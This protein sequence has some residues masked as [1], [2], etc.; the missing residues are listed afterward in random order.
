MS[1]WNESE[2][3]RRHDVVLD[4]LVIRLAK[5]KSFLFINQHYKRITPEKS[6]EGEMDVMSIRTVDG[7]QYHRYYEVKSRNT[8]RGYE[9]AMK[10][11]VRHKLAYADTG[12]DWKYIYVTP[13]RVER[14]RL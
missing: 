2:H 6:Y 10:Q 12:Q 7:R 5:K 9:T 11:F 13:Q 1:R 4:E 14:I 8:D 3:N